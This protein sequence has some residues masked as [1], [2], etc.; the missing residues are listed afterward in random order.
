MA[1]RARLQK[2]LELAHASDNSRKN[3]DLLSYKAANN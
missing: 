2:I 1:V 3:V